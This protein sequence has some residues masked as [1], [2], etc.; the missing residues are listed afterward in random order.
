M[1]PLSIY[2]DLSEEEKKNFQVSD[3]DEWTDGNAMCS[4]TEAMYIFKHIQS[5][6]FPG[7]PR[8]RY[9]RSYMRIKKKNGKFLYTNFTILRRQIYFLIPTQEYIT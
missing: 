1:K 7:K 4:D 6:D 3:K 8:K 5:V 9:R 2:A